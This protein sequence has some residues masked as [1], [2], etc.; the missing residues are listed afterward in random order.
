MITFHKLPYCDLSL[1][2]L[3]DRNLLHHDLKWRVKEAKKHNLT[4]IFLYTKTY[5]HLFIERKLNENKM[6]RNMHMHMYSNSVIIETKC[7]SM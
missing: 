1:D 3:L 2:D 5:K 6:K 7:K 4:K